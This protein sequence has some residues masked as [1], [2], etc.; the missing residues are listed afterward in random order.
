MGEISSEI[1]GQARLLL[2]SLALGLWLMACYDLIRISRILISKVG[3][4]A[5]SADITRLQH[6]RF[7]T[8]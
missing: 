3:G 8:E 2:E 4:P 1:Y 6:H 5:A 7:L